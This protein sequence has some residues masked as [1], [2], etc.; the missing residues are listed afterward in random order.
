MV[1]PPRTARA[2]ATWRSSSTPMA[3]KSGPVSRARRDRPPRALRRRAVER[4]RRPRWSRCST[5]WDPSSR[6]SSAGSRDALKN[7]RQGAGG[8]R[9]QRRDDRPDGRRVRGHDDACT[10]ASSVTPSPS[11]WCRVTATRS[12]RRWRSGAPLAELRRGVRGL[13]RRVQDRATPPAVAE[14]NYRRI[15]DAMSRFVESDVFIYLRSDT[16]RDF[17]QFREILANGNAVA[18]PPRLRRLRQVPRLA[19]VRVSARRAHQARHRSQGQ[20]HRRPRSRRQVR[21]ALARGRVRGDRAG[22][23]ES[24]TPLR[25]Q[26]RDRRG[27]S[28]SGRR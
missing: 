27:S 22:V 9:S 23:R 28:S 2:R 18:Q 15:V 8:S 10:S 19:V 13:N 24:R 21:E 6:S 7:D 4:A 5:G 26:R 11:A 3:R 25:P 12:A 20:D 16:R 14:T 17:W 1:A